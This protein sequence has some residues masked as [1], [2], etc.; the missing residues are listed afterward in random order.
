MKN[1]LLIFSLFLSFKAFALYGSK[2]ES[3]SAP[4]VVTLELNDKN[5]PEENDFCSGVLVSPT[6]VLTAGHCIDV[7]GLNVYDMG[8]ALTYRPHLVNVIVG[9][10]KI[11]AHR[12]TLSPSYN[13]GFGF[14]AEDLAMIELSVPVKNVKPIKLAGRVTLK[15]GINVDLIVRHSKVTT[16]INEI[17]NYPYTKVMILNR[18]AGACRGDSGGAVVV[19]ENGQDALAGILMYDGGSTCYKKNGHAYVAKLQFSELL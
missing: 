5:H 7:T 19:N 1:G 8:P 9:G 14:S 13:E 10:K 15:A 18:E 3:A 12:I 16:K 17:K 6:K 2:V 11:R 4:Y